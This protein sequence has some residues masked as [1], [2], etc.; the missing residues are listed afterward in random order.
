MNI[1]AILSVRS[2]EWCLRMLR[3][4]S[5][6]MEGGVQDRNDCQQN[7]IWR[8]GSVAVALRNKEF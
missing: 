2:S 4:A 5:G 1:I 3:Y 7:G 6:H 8:P